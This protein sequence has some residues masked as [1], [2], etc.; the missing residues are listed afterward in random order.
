MGSVSVP[1]GGLVRLHGLDPESYR[2]H[3]LH[4][5]DR[6]YREIN[7]YADILVELLHARGQEPLAAMGAALALDFEGD[8]WTFFKP[9]PEDLELLYGLDVHEMQPYRPLP[10]QIAE[11]I[12]AGRTLTVELDSWHMPDTAAT[13]YHREH[14]KSSIIPEAIDQRE[15]RLL[16]FHATGLHELRGEDYR[17]IFRLDGDPGAALPPYTELVRF[18]LTPPLQGEELRETARRLLRRHLARRPTSNPFL[19]FGAQ[20]TSELPRLLEGDQA[21]YHAYAFATVRMAGSGF[22]LAGSHVEW[23][24]GEAGAPARSAL[25]EIV[26]GCKVLSFRLARRRPFEP[27]PALATLAAAWD[28]GM[29]RLDDAIT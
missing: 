1:A 13:S 2:S 24:L 14:V 25:T 28:E 6:T 21:D 15:E 20:L 10:Q 12:A 19:R 22:E 23:L 18:D 7:C 11:L 8:Q 16:Y 27:E 4:G 17:G 26:E 9:A 29:A 5:P 3:F